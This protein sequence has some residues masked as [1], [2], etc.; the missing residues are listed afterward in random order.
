[1]VTIAK[2]V[3]KKELKMTLVGQEIV[4]NMVIITYK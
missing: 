3:F 1:M 4:F 2:N